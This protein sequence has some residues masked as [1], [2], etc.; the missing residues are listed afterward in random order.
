M[1][2]GVIAGHYKRAEAEFDVALLAERPYAEVLPAAPHAPDRRG[3][4]AGDARRRDRA[5]P[6]GDRR[7]RAPA[8]RSRPLGDGPGAA[9]VATLERALARRSRI[10][11]RRPGAQ[12]HLASQRARGRR[13]R[14]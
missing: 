3:L 9:A 13:L 4:P 1:L 8:V 6:P 5:R 7:H 10:R 12:E 2:P 14:V 11:A